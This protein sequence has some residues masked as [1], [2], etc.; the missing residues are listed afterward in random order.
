MSQRVSGYA[1]VFADTYETPAPPVRALVPYLRERDL[2]FVLEPANGPRS[3]L[4][5]TLRNEGFHVT[6]TGSDFLACTAMPDP[7]IE[8]IVTNPPFGSGG[9]YAEVFIE[10]ALAL[11]PFVAMLLRIDFDSG[12]TRTRLFGD[13]PFFAGK[14]ILLDRIVWFPR[15]GKAGPSENH[16]WYL[17]DRRHQGAPTI[18]YARAK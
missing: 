11:A 9:R 10:H 5:Q 4:A 7:G 18:R 1:R 13:C 15:E 8:G 2:Q 16:A 6:A 12:K 17:W 14:L 3:M